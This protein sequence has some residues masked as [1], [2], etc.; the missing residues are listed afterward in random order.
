[1]PWGGTLAAP[2]ESNQGLNTEQEQ[3]GSRLG[4]RVP[5]RAPDGRQHLRPSGIG[6]EVEEG[7]APIP[8]QKASIRRSTGPAAYRV[9][10]RRRRQNHSGAS[11]RS[12]R[13]GTAPVVLEA[14]TSLTRALSSFALR[15]NRAEP[16][17]PEKRI[18]L[19]RR[20]FS[21]PGDNARVRLE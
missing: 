7:G 13:L 18:G 4:G 1:M 8:I 2:G 11:F 15:C 9:S 12:P 20:C 17:Q 19:N 5:A 3:S 6:G 21:S 16:P 10:G 14:R